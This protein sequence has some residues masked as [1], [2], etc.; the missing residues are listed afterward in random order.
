MLK[1]LSEMVTGLVKEMGVRRVIEANE[2]ECNQ[3]GVLEASTVF[4]VER[5]VMKLEG[6]GK[7][8]M[9]RKAME[10]REAGNMVK[11]MFAKLAKEVNVLLG[12]KEMSVNGKEK[13]LSPMPNQAVGVIERMRRQ[14]TPP[15]NLLS[16]F[17]FALSLSSKKEVVGVNTS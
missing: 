17:K 13:I 16:D 9:G 3:A 5:Q 4:K 1:I 15:I 6:N 8:M 12:N 14:L 10:L 11:R 7:V 2:T